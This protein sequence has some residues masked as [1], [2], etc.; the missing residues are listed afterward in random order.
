MASPWVTSLYGGV[1][2]AMNHGSGR[3]H[4]SAKFDLASRSEIGSRDSGR[5]LDVLRHG[6][7]VATAAGIATLISDGDFGEGVPMPLDVSAARRLVE[8]LLAW[9]M[10]SERFCDG[11]RALIWTS[12][13][14]RSA[15]HAHHDQGDGERVGGFAAWTGEEG[16]RTILGRV[17]LAGRS[18]IGRES[19]RPGCCPNSRWN[20]QI[21]RPTR[22]RGLGR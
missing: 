13:R 12:D 3:G 19:Q 8:L 17:L 9:R 1:N 14:R 22:K 6:A 7:G 16:P 21:V 11:A 15:E 2:G 10:C 5:L 18:E 4:M 20:V